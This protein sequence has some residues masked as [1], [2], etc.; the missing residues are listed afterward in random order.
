MRTEQ[1]YV[2]GH[3]ALEIERLQLQGAVIAPVTRRL[4]AQSGIGPGMHVLDI[5]C[6]IGDVSMLLAEAVGMTG[7]VVAFDREPRA[8]EIARARAL[9]A[10]YRCIEFVVASDA[11]F[12]AQT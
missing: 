7:N 5:G 12:P 2:L 4:V 8:V 10:G 1:A 6:G 3:E 9:A 11:S